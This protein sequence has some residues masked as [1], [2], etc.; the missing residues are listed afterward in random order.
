MDW[1]HGR[2]SQQSFQNGC[3]QSVICSIGYHFLTVELC[4]AVIKSCNCQPNPQ[5]QAWNFIQYLPSVVLWLK[6][7]GVTLFSYASNVYLFPQTHGPLY[8][9]KH[10]NGACNWQWETKKHSYPKWSSPVTKYTKC[11]IYNPLYH[12]R[13]RIQYVRCTLALEK[14]HCKSTF[15]PWERWAEQGRNETKVSHITRAS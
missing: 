3:R 10:L 6:M 14:Q 1:E 12:P 11:N 9:L 7:A 15:L 2:L 4:S 13:S 8:Y 5:S